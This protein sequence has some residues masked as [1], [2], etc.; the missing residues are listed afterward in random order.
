MASK[1]TVGKNFRS[2]PVQSEVLAA[3]ARLEL[4]AHDAGFE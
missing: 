4:R 2:G 1:V 3:H